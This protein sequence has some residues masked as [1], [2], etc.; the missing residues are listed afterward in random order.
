MTQNRLKRSAYLASNDAFCD[1]TLRSLLLDGQAPQPLR[2]DS[3]LGYFGSG[4]WNDA[5]RLCHRH[6]FGSGWSQIKQLSM[7]MRHAGFIRKLRREHIDILFLWRGLLGR[8]GLAALAAKRAN[9]P[10]IYFERGPLPG[11]VQIDRSGVNARNSVPRDPAFFRR[12][13][14]EAGA[15]TDWRSLKDSLVARTPRRDLVA[16]NCRDDWTKEGKFLFC[17]FQ[18]NAARDML[19][20]GGWVGDPAKL[21]LALARASG[22]LPEGWHIRVKPHPNAPGDL[23]PLIAP[24]LGEKLRLDRDTNSLDQLRA[25]QG[26]IT[27]NSAMG[28]EAFFFDKPVIVLGDSY[29][30]DKGR[31][32]I[33]TSQAELDRLLARPEQLGF[34]Q[35][36]RDNLMTFLFNDYFI[37]EQDLRDGA[38]SLDVILDRDAR[39]QR[40]LKQV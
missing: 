30:S 22:H 24:H 13:R 31:T 10:C 4:N 16:Q 15:V 12:W 27:V 11:W 2:L 18:L 19:P 21:V 20:D 23:G 3:R 29:Y 8:A 35:A 28:L 5:K 7:A 26:V 36:A 39:H 34:D 6:E 9:I 40:L 38:V 17:P 25:S 33:A 14:D 37:R 32:D 1:E